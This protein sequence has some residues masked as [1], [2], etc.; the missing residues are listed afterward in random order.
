MNTKDAYK[1]LSIINGVRAL[2][3]G[4]KAFGRYMVRREA[5][6]TLARTMRQSG[7]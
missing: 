6:K 2:L 4:P 1:A 7:L 3:R 5:H